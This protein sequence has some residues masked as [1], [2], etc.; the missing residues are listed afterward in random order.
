MI[1][2]QNSIYALDAL[3]LQ[4]DSLMVSSGFSHPENTTNNFS[5]VTSN[6]LI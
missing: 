1:L 4:E 5:N 3:D 2:G 6:I